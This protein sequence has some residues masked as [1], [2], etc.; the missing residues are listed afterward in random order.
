MNLI[1]VLKNNHLSAK[2]HI[3][4]THQRMAAAVWSLE[5]AEQNFVNLTANENVLSMTSS[6]FLTM[7]LG[8]RY[9][10]EDLTKPPSSALTAAKGDFTFPS[11]GAVVNFVREGQQALS[12][13]LGADWVEMRPLSGVHA[14]LVTLASLTSLGDTVFSLAPGQGGHFATAPLAS[15]IGRHG[16]FI[17]WNERANEPDYRKLCQKLKSRCGKA[18]IFIDPGLPL[19]PFPL[20]K[21]R[22]ALG[23]NVT[24]VYDASHCLGLIAGN[25]FLNPFN[26]G[27][28]IV[29]GNTHKSF[30]GAHKGIIAG[31]RADLFQ[32]I[33]SVLDNELVSS[34]HTGALLANACTALEM[35]AYGHD[36]ARQMTSL[37]RGLENELASLGHPTISGSST[38][39]VALPVADTSQAAAVT[40]NLMGVGMRVNSRV[41]GK[42]PLLRL[43]LQELTRRGLQLDD[44]GI[45]AGILANSLENAM[46]MEKHR[47][48]IKELA[49]RLSSTTY[50]FDTK[51]VF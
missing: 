44:L 46:Q 45:L 37:A 34:C 7:K 23:P 10:L 27:A 3:P 24:I 4:K 35:Q 20:Q 30:P 49:R 13:M 16:L 50:S 25:V 2:F 38:H 29:Q 32:S 5:A 22:D 1:S 17:P 39:I 47:G 36:Y 31:R 19:G 41:V 42:T 6:R 40:A 26:E 8:G 11:L 9:L 28:D 21:L 48:E 14:T 12:A 33:R 15:R 43:G 51:G 18:L